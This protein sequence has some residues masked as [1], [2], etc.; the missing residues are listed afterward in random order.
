MVWITASAAAAAS[1]NALMSSNVA[2]KNFRAD[3]GQRGRLVT[4]TGEASD[5]VARFQKLMVTAEPTQPVAPV[6]NT[7]M[8]IS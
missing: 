2:A 8:A 3:R 7:C 6:T 5:V 1:R 4:G